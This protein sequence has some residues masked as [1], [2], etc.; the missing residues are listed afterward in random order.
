MAPKRQL[1]NNPVTVTGTSGRP[2]DAH[3]QPRPWGRAPRTGGFLDEAP[4]EAG[5][6]CLSLRSPTDAR[7]GSTRGILPAM[8]V[9]ELADAFGAEHLRER[10]VPAPT[11]GAGEVVLRMLA[12]SLN[13]RD[14]LMIEGRYDRRQ[15][16]PFIPVSDGVGV[17]VA[18][19]AGVT[20]LTLG[21]RVCPLLLPRWDAGEPDKATLRGGLG[22][23]LP[24]V[25]SEL[26]VVQAGHVVRVPDHLTDVEAATLPCAAL[27]AWSALVELGQVRAGDVVLVQGTGGV[28]LFALAFAK[29]CGAAVLITS[30]SAE[31]LERARALGADHGIHTA[32]EPAWGDAARRWTG[33]RGVD[34]VVEIGGAGTLAESLR[35]VRPGGT[36]SI[37][38]VLAGTRGTF[39]VLPVLMNQV[40][41]QGVFCGH[42]QGFVAMNRAIAA[43]R[44]RPV[45]DRTFP[46]SVAGLTEA[47]RVLE[48]GAHFGK[49]ALTFPASPAD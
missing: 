15:P 29:L 5:A 14:L 37:I 28:A 47:L 39:D 6:R 19:G 17:V 21:D 22:G 35:A 13:F 26:R 45:V 18:V 25:L 30:R 34:H 38:G 7:A 36:L 4:A 46:A 32:A 27:T 40:R 31:K 33:Q 20:E 16:L 11:P 44:L 2:S 49:L 41:L 1:R 8:R 24:G 42:R 23:P 12:A 9:I 3:R 10:E 48:S 43:A